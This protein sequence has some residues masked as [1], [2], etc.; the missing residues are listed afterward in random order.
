MY[1]FYEQKVMKEKTELAEEMVR[2]IISKLYPRATPL[3]EW[4]MDFN[5]LV[6]V[7]GEG[8]DHLLARQI[9]LK[10][11]IPKQ[12]LLQYRR[13]GEAYVL[14]D[15][16]ALR[17]GTSRGGLLRKNTW[18]SI[19]N[20]VYIFVGDRLYRKM[21]FRGKPPIKGIAEAASFEL[22]QEEEKKFLNY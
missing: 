17:I 13:S 7:S 11:W 16:V 22:E 6:K 3:H 12:G 18:K 4:D 21:N 9:V 2:S 19:E 1:S 5:V 8:N 15:I 10:Y 14:G 20:V